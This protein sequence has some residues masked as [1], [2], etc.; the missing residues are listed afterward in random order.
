MDSKDLASRLIRRWDSLKAVREKTEALRWEAMAYANHRTKESTAGYSPVPE[1]TYFTS[2]SV[3]AIENFIN[4][5]LGNIVSQNQ[6]WA[7]FRYE[8]KDFTEQDDIQGANQYLGLCQKRVMS[9]LA[10][11][12][13]YSEDRLAYKDAFVGGCSA[14]FVYN[15]DERE[16]TVFKTLQPW[17]WW[18][19]FNKFGEYDTFFY[20]KTMTAYRAYQQFG[21][22]LPEEIKKVV[23][24]NGGYD[25][26]YDFLMCIYPRD[27]KKPKR[28]Q[29][30]KRMKYACVWL[31]LSYS[32]TVNKTTKGYIINEGGYN[33]FPVVIHTWDSDGENPYG[34]SPVIRALPELRRMNMVAYES[35]FALRKINHSAHVMTPAVSEAFSDEPEAKIIVPSMEQAPVPLQQTQTIDGA[36]AMEER[37]EEKISRIFYNDMFNYLS[38]QDKVFTA[39]QVNAVKSEELSLLSAIFGN[40][41]SQKINKLIKLVIAIMA[42]KKRLPEGAYEAIG[43]GKNGTLKIVLDSM[44]AQS[45]KAYTYR[46]SAIADLELCAQISQLGQVDQSWLDSMDNIDKNRLVRLAL[47]GNGTDP[48]VI[49]DKAEVEMIQKQ[50]AEARAQQAQLQAQLAQSEMVRNMGGASN[51]NNSTGANQYA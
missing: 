29:F 41:Q 20:K 2:H 44:L 21:E 48:S 7:S 22:K 6:N 14:Q 32:G 15:D 38:R 1:L 33:D 42:E 49:V 47:S 19:D 35:S 51:L 18:C 10:N 23:Y 40:I 16:I 31:S 25:S 45:L 26:E 27:I 17:D 9:E 50:K 36:I 13:F 43:D 3:I 30:P 34:T 37:Q 11:S 12:N 24:E 39:T 4:G 46:D 5:F 28:T 8:S